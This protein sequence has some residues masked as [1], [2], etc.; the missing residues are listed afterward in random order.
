MKKERSWES[1]RRDLIFGCITMLS[2]LSLFI[3]I[4]MICFSKEAKQTEEGYQRQS[5]E[6]NIADDYLDF[7]LEYAQQEESL[8][9]SSVEGETGDSNQ[10]GAPELP[11]L[12][13]KINPDLSMEDFQKMIEQD[14]NYLERDGV[15]YT[16][17]YAKGYLAFVLDIPSAG[18]KRGVYGG[19]WDEIYYNLDIWM[20]TM[21]RPDYELGKTHMCIYGHNH[22]AQNLS[23]NEI[24][25]VK[26]GDLFYIYANSGYY[27]YEVT[28]IAART[29]EDVTRNLVDNFS[30]G[31]DKC[32]I[33]TCGRDY[34]LVD[35][36]S[37]R[38]KDVVVEGTLKE[39]MS[40]L[41]YAKKVKNKKD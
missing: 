38:Y 7:L 25:K 2:A 21:G 31:S 13:P 8:Y 35:G 4:Y 19:T 41:E 9:E 17:D 23:F 36:K 3:G 37:S 26:K 10:Q 40:L 24:D 32:Y 22:T 11:N 14:P 28:D 16:P 30:I 34:F 39:H 20:V 27:E 29:R 5:E 1:K 33:L 15:T 12:P 18:I 6:E